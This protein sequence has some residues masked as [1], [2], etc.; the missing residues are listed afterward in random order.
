MFLIRPENTVIL[1]ALKYRSWTEPEE[2]ASKLAG[3]AKIS[4]NRTTLGSCLLCLYGSRGTGGGLAAPAQVL[5]TV[6]L[7][8]FI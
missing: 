1:A 5:H 4:E 7:V 2:E 3:D 6:W 8:D